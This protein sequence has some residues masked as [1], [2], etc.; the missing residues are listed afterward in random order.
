[1]STFDR[2]RFLKTAA[3]TAGAAAA[4]TVFPDSIRKALA[5]PAASGT[6][7]IQ[8]VEHI[9][10]LM[11][12]NRSFDHYFGH[13]RGVRGYNDRFP[14][15]LAS[16]QPVWYQPSKE[17]PAQPVLPFRFNVNQVSECLGDLDH[18]W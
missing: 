4:L 17:N 3:T 9:V 12:E 6:N 16:G 11:Q 5:I 7:S 15:P 14:I 2:R 1:M 10:V 13:L 8:D 18:N